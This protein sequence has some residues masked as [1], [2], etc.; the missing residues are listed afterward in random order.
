MFYI[1]KQKY[2]VGPSR[3]IVENADIHC[4]H[5]VHPRTAART[6]A[7]LE[8]FSLELF[9]CP[10]YSPDLAPKDCGLFTCLKNWL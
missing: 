8:H 2:C 10:S 4:T 9:D 6:R 7:L 5:S 3:T 1:A